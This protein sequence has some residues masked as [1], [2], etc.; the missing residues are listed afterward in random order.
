MPSIEWN[1]TKFGNAEGFPNR[2]E[3]WS[4]PWGGSYAQWYGVILPRIKKFLPC[5]SILEIAPGFGRWTSFLLDLCDRYTG[6]DIS[7]TCIENLKGRFHNGEFIKNDGYSLEMIADNK[8]DF[9]FSFDSLVHAEMDVI[10]S[11]L[12]QIPQKLTK[13]GVAFLHIS[14][15][16]ACQQTENI[17]ARAKS[18]SAKLVRDFCSKHNINLVVQELINWRGDALIDQFI[19]INRQKI[20]FEKPILIVNNE[21]MQEAKICKDIYMKYA[22]FTCPR[23]LFVDINS[24]NGIELLKQENCIPVVVESNDYYVPY[25]SV[26]LKSLLL[27]SSSDYYYDIIILHSDISEKSK[28]LIRDDVLGFNNKSIRFINIGDEVKEIEFKIELP[29]ISKETFYRLLIPDIMKDYCKIVFLDCDLIVKGDISELYNINLD[30]NAIGATL[31]VDF[32]GRY[33]DDVKGIKRYVDENLKLNDPYKY[34]QAG[35]MIMD[36]SVM[37]DLLGDI[38]LIS[39]AINKRYRYMDQDIL[40][41]VFHAHV[42]HIDL[43]WNVLCD[44]CNIR[45]SKF[46]RRGPLEYYNMYLEARKN[47]KIIHYAGAEKPWESPYMDYAFEYFNYARKSLFYEIIMYRLCKKN[48]A[49]LMN[50]ATFGSNNEWIYEHMGGDIYSRFIFPW[51]AVKPG[52]RIVMYGGGI[53][54]KTFL[55]QVSNNPY[56]H[57]IAVVD[58]N[59]TSTG[60]VEAPVIGLNELVGIECDSY[61]LILIALERKDIALNVRDDLELMGIP[62]QKIRWVDPHRV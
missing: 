47:P 5:K 62:S 39:Y 19:I 42:K 15:L 44:C 46:I 17:H 50:I 37:R 24:E 60:I 54:G 45:V 38:K 57:I 29:H 34:F 31:D 18:V 9:I 28:E 49:S 3:V 36:L 58:Q 23:K 20:S 56:C 40:N 43:R 41:L 16:G 11:Y 12:K 48:A 61:D 4:E 2:G 7:R 52:D 25:T 6:V 32:A 27:N 13:N 22:D 10:E 33:K 35:V 51:K 8:Y 30:G 21:F 14:N 55:R 1:K 59:P 26:T 53:V